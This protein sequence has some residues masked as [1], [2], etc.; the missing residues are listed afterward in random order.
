MNA[1]H[2]SIIKSP[3]FHEGIPS[4]DAIYECI[5]R[6]WIV[7]MPTSSYSTEQ[8]L[9]IVFDSTTAS[10]DPLV[11]KPWIDM[12]R[13]QE[14]R[15][16]DPDWE[17]LWG[18]SLADI[19]AFADFLSNKCIGIGLE[20][21]FKGLPCLLYFAFGVEDD[22]VTFRAPPPLTDNKYNAQDN[23][24]NLLPSWFQSF[25]INVHD[26][27]G[28]LLFP[29]NK[30]YRLNY[31]TRLSSW[32]T[33]RAITPKLT[34]SYRTEDII[35]LADHGGAGDLFAFDS[36]KLACGDE[37]CAALYWHETPSKVVFN[38]NIRS[39]FNDLIVFAFS[40]LQ[41]R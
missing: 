33:D 31:I 27:F 40:G 4:I 3:F 15:S 10:T 6:D 34:H 7:E 1:N 23:I 32:V 9:D 5:D 12:L 35:L 14:S 29:P 16:G 19:P 2:K 36:H 17:Q 22:L 41:S 24:F 37:N 21:S 8:P 28:L 39:S 20:K 13:A 25:Y 30:P 18:S 11:P 38:Q 26:G